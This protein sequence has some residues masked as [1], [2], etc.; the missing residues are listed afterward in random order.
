MCSF[1]VAWIEES[2]FPNPLGRGCR[3]STAQEG[4]LLAAPAGWSDF[5]CLPD[6]SHLQHRF[7]SAR[8]RWHVS[9][10]HILSLRESVVMQLAESLKVGVQ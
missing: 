4:V 3:Q 6:P 9:A 8:S 1:H 2:G 5:L 10:Q 7:A